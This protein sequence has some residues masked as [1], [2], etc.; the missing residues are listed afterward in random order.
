MFCKEDDGPLC[1]S[2]CWRASRFARAVLWPS[3][4]SLVKD[5]LRN[6]FSVNKLTASG[7]SFS[8]IYSH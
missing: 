7:I 3:H 2:V 6:Y 4:P 8:E 1:N 5:V